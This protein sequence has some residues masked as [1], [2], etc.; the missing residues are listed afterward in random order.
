MKLHPRYQYIVV[1]ETGVLDVVDLEHILPQKPDDYWLRRLGNDEPIEWI[2]RLGNLTVIDKGLNRGIQN[3]SFIH[4]KKKYQISEI[5]ITRDLVRSK[6]WGP[7][8]IDKRQ[9]KFAKLAPN[10]WKL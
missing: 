9:R 2:H 10:I 7:S 4:K 3:K 5:K 8:S 6:D 1:S